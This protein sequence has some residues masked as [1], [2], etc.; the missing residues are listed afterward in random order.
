MNEDELWWFQRSS[1]GIRFLEEEK[2]GVGKR[3]DS[4]RGHGEALDMQFCVELASGEL[5]AGSFAHVRC[6]EVGEGRRWWFSGRRDPGYA[7]A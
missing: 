2:R 7:L 1:I 4:W 3:E 5:T 6:G